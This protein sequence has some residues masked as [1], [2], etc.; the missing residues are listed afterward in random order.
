MRTPT[1]PNMSRAF[2]VG[3]EALGRLRPPTRDMISE[4][5]EAK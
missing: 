1:P 3:T 4:K 2:S 5:K